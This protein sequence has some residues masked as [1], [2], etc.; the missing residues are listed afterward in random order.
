MTAINR[1]AL[2]ALGASTFSA[3]GAER[4]PGPFCPSQLTVT[5]NGVDAAMCTTC[6]GFNDDYRDLAVDGVYDIAYSG[7]DT[8]R[9]TYASNFIDP[10]WY[11]HDAYYYSGVSCSGTIRA[12]CD[13][14]LLRFIIF[15]LDVTADPVV[16]NRIIL[17]GLSSPTCYVA[18]DQQE[19]IFDSR[20]GG[21]Q[22]DAW[23]DNGALPCGSAHSP[24]SA[25][26]GG[27]IMVTR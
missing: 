6:N 24:V 18:G 12:T 22:L 23:I 3:L 13:R 14:N 11:T 17:N 15:N 8:N 7:G 21:W 16:F 1:L 9:C 10:I 27:Q 20:H 25:P 26:G 4:R 5:V 19:V 2:T